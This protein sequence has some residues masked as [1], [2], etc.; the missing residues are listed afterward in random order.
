MHPVWIIGLKCGSKSYQER[1][2]CQIRVKIEKDTDDTF[3]IC[4][5]PANCLHTLHASMLSK[6]K[7]IHIPNCDPLR[8]ILSHFL[9]FPNPGGRIFRCFDHVSQQCFTLTRYD[10]LANIPL[11]NVT[12]ANCNT[13]CELFILKII[14]HFSKKIMAY[15]QF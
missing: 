14:R 5:F 1:N 13:L 9:R 4:S 7:V 15:G 6:I 2:T 12:S 8:H 11:R 10:C 3:E